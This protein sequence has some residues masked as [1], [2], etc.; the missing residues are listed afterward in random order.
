MPVG[1]RREQVLIIFGTAF[2][3]ALAHGALS[4]G[5]VRILV[6]S[7]TRGGCGVIEIEI[8]EPERGPP[9]L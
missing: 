8:I 9:F 2:D 4:R 6:F 1:V 5:A 3:Q 7:I